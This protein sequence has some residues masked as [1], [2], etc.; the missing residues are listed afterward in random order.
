V[1]AHKDRRVVAGG[2]KHDVP[3]EAKKVGAT[4]SGFAEALAR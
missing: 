1:A 2:E 4:A 3:Y